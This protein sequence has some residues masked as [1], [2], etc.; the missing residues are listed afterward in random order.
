MRI[1]RFNAL[2]HDLAAAESGKLSQTELMSLSEL[3]KETTEMLHHDLVDRR[4]E[5]LLKPTTI[6]QK[7]VSVHF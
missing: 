2:P 4:N 6:Q 1:Y 3:A 7:M 5:L